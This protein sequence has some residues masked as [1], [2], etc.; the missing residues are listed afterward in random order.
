MV[1]TFNSRLKRLYRQPQNLKWLGGGRGTWACNL[2]FGTIVLFQQGSLGE[3]FDSKLLVPT[4]ST[5]RLIVIYQTNA[6]SRSLI[7]FRFYADLGGCLSF[8][9]TEWISPDHVQKTLLVGHTSSCIEWWNMD[10][11][12]ICKMAISTTDT[13]HESQWSTIDDVWSEPRPG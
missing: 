9:H 3:H 13:D 4:N 1:L 2:R 6:D 12:Y 11:C 10:E 7:E 5:V 8:T